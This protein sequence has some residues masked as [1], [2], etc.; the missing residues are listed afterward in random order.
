[1][2]H[3]IDVK[4]KTKTKPFDWKKIQKGKKLDLWT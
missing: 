2:K 1:M 4:V 3:H